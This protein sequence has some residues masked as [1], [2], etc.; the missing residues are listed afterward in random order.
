MVT[1]NNAA[2]THPAG[3]GYVLSLSEVAH[4]ISPQQEKRKRETRKDADPS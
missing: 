1:L 3:M 2:L 4:Q